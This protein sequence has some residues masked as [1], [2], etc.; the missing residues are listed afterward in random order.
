M[1]NTIWATQYEV[2]FQKYVCVSAATITSDRFTLAEGH[3][4]KQ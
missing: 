4:F 2:V 3:K 1:K